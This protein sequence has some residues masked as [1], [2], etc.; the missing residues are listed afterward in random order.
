MLPSLAGDGLDKMNHAMITYVKT[1]VD[2]LANKIKPMDLHMWCRH[3][4]T[5]ASTDAVYGPQNPFKNPQTE[6]DFWYFL[7]D[8]SNPSQF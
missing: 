1:S 7:P 4:I 8:P 5:V 2:G 3:A 6:Q